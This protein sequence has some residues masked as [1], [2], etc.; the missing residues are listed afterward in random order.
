MDPQAPTAAGHRARAGRGWHVVDSQ[1]L[2]IV[3]PHFGVVVPGQVH[4]WDARGV[5]GSVLLF[6]EDFLVRHSQDVPVLAALHA[7]TWLSLTGVQ[8]AALAALVA[9]MERELAAAEHGHDGVLR[10]YLHILIMRAA[11]IAGALGA[12]GPGGVQQVS[13]LVERFLRLIAAPGQGSRTLTSSPA[14]RRTTPTASSTR[15]C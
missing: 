15:G 11:R 2:P 9:E 10:S 6:N 4:H 3:P 1:P 5:E 14:C 7:L 8:L 13:E 12:P